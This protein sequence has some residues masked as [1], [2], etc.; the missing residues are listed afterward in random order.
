M[1]F[2]FVSESNACCLLPCVQCDYFVSEHEEDLVVYLQDGSL[3]QKDLE[4]DLCV[5]IT[6]Q[7][8]TCSK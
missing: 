8:A 2:N 6:G 5:E 7:P 1:Y 4:D 3:S